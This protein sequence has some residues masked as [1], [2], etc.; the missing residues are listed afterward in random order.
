MKAK[1]RPPPYFENTDRAKL[2][3]AI[4][5][6]THPFACQANKVACRQA[7]RALSFYH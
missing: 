7:G 1:E 4:G 2:P 5:T 6:N 3:I